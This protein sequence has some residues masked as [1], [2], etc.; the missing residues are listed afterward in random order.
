MDF[1]FIYNSVQRIKSVIYRN[2]G[3]KSETVVWYLFVGVVLFAL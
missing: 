3:L 2:A 1:G